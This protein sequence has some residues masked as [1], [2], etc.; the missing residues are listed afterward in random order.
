MR[1][2]FAALLPILAILLTAA[3]RDEGISRARVPKEE[4]PAPAMGMGGEM[5]HDEAGHDHSA[6]A[7]GLRWTL[8]SGWK[9]VPGTGMRLAT[10][11]PPGGLKTEGTVVSLP[12]DSGGELANANRWRGQIGLPA[13]DEAGVAAARTKLTTKA[14][15]VSVYD[16]TSGGAVKTRLI[17]AVVKSGDSTWF[18]KLMGEAGATESARGG[19]LQL[20]KSLAPDAQK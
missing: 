18:F 13:T 17:A 9:E 4:A 20:I 14:G 10:L 16:F 3:C 8:P 5:P 15:P 6:H 2:N 12:G 7:Q 1:T 19:F 11:V